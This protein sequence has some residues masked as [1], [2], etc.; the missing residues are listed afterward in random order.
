MRCQPLARWRGVSV[1]TERPATFRSST[2]ASVCS[3]RGSGGTVG[4]GRGLAVRWKAPES[5]RYF[6]RRLS[7]NFAAL[8]LRLLIRP[9]GC[10]VRFGE[11]VHLRDEE[12]H[13]PRFLAIEAARAEARRAGHDTGAGGRR[14]QGRL[15]PRAEDCLDAPDADVS[16]AHGLESVGVNPGG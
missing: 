10:P 2:F 6:L 8:I 15:L 13:R 5:E 16:G 3:A 1:Y 11:H 12:R 7:H 9:P 14:P 4:Y